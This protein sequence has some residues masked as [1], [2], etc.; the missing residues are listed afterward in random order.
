MKTWVQYCKNGLFGASY[1]ATP[2]FL[3][4]LEI[5]EPMCPNTAFQR[6][7]KMVVNSH[8]PITNTLRPFSSALFPVMEGIFKQCVLL[9]CIPLRKKELSHTG[10][11][12]RWRLFLASSKYLEERH[13]HEGRVWWAE[14]KA[15]KVLQSSRGV[16]RLLSKE[17]GAEPRLELYSFFLCSKRGPHRGLATQKAAQWTE[18][19]TRRKDPD[20]KVSVGRR[21]V[22]YK[23]FLTSVPAHLATELSSCKTQTVL[24]YMQ[25]K[26]G[27][28]RMKVSFFSTLESSL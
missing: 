11:V 10:L 7:F 6:F 26:P 19:T 14:E 25:V 16:E 22:V 15:K 20:N 28:L 27:L 18:I 9:C 17:Q 1:K 24:V 12:E 2:A 4:L 3:A 5:H 13:F 8:P 21:Q 23:F